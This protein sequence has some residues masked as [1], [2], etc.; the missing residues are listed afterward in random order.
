MASEREAS[1]R[2]RVAVDLLGWCISSVF[3]VTLRS[4]EVTESLLRQ[5]PVGNLR[6]PRAEFAALWIE[7]ER[8]N[9]VE[10]GRS[11][12]DWY[13]AAIAV[14]CRWLAAAVVEDQIGRRELAPAPVTRRRGRAYEELSC[15]AV[16]RLPG[17]QVVATRR[18]W[19]GP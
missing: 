5:V 13:P 16:S 8:L 11:D 1:R 17:L 6:V 3:R 7:A 19:P 12:P 2:I 14:T 9:R 10:T 4:V 18:G 15:F